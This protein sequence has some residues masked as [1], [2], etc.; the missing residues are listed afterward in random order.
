MIGGQILVDV[1]IQVDAYLSLSEAHFIADHVEKNLMQFSRKIIDI[2]VHMDPEND[3]GSISAL[4]L[5]SRKILEK[6]LNRYWQKLPG[7]ENIQKINLY[8]LKGKIE[9]E[10]LMM[11]PNF[12]ENETSKADILVEKYQTAIKDINY[13]Y[14]V[15]IYF[16]TD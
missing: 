1:H 4:N 12:Y 9:I 10:V 2:T 15:K 7:Y 5:P 11:L 14:S 6:T 13:I 3:D 16:S 8:Y